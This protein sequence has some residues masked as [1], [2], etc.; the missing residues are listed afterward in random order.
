VDT[1]LILMEEHGC[2]RRL[3]RTRDDAAGE[4]FGLRA[5]SASAIPAAR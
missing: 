3:G 2:Y 1:D 5:C 4:A